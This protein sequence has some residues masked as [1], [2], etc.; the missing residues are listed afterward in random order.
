MDQETQMNGNCAREAELMR[1]HLVS[2]LKKMWLMGYDR[3]YEEGKRTGRE[4][5]TREAVANAP[6]EGFKVGDILE[7]TNSTDTYRTVVTHIE[8]NYYTLMYSDGSSIRTKLGDIPWIKIGVASTMGS[9]M[10]ELRR[11]IEDEV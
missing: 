9:I 7:H 3:G 5:A 11:G 1:N 6:K 8:G 2:S 10:S 4:E